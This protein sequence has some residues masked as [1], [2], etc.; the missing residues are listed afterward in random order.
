MSGVV[1][2]VVVAVDGCGVIIMLFVFFSQFML[3][4]MFVFGVTLVLSNIAW[5]C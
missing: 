3:S 1:V 5:C 4:L 2:V